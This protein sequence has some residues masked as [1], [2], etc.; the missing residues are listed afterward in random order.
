MKR[1]LVFVAALASAFLFSSG[2]VAAQDEEKK[3]GGIAVVDLQG[4]LMQ[5]EEGL[6]AQT[7]LKKLFDK[8]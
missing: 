2:D 6:K 1:P 5:T 3:S 8:R 7:Q 4:A